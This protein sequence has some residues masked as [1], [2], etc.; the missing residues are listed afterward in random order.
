MKGSA[1]GHVV[2]DDRHLAGYR[3]VE[4]GAGAPIGDVGNENARQAFEQLGLQVAD[5][6]GPRR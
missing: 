1:E 2:E 6:A 5:A 3:V 4:R